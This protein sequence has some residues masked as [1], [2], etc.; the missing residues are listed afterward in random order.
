MGATAEGQKELLAVQDG[1]RESTQSWT[2]LLVE[3]KAFRGWGVT[4]RRLVQPAWNTTFDNTSSEVGRALLKFVI[5]LPPERLVI[6]DN[7]W[8][9]S[10]SA[11]R[12]KGGTGRYQD[13]RTID[14]LLVFEIGCA[15]PMQMHCNGATRNPKEWLAVLQQERRELAV[16][17]LWADWPAVERRARNCKPNDVLMPKIWHELYRLKS[18][19]VTFPLDAQ[20]TERVIDTSNMTAE[21]VAQEILSDESLVGW[22]S[23]T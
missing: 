22:C 4:G 3:R 9:A 14:P 2:E 5:G 17:Q 1:Y 6:L 19:L 23:Q 18:E 10:A 12:S 8:D 15:E 7:G 11:F 16:F 21:E 20:I 13:L